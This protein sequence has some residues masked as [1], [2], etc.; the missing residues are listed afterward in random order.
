MDGG[1]SS[2]SLSLWWRRYDRSSFGWVKEKGKMIDLSPPTAGF[3]FLFSSYVYLVV[4]SFSP[5]TLKT[6]D[7][8]VINSVTAGYVFTLTMELSGG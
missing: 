7:T 8:A 3:L 4:M 5:L 6:L 2:S 1:F